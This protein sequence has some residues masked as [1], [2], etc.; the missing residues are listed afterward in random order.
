MILLEAAASRFALAVAP[1]GVTCEPVASLRKSIAAVAALNDVLSPLSLPD[2]LRAFWTWWDA[3]DF[4]QPALDGFFSPED[5]L[6]RREKL[7]GI[8]YPTSLIPFAAYG[9]GL[10]WMELQSDEHPGSRVYHGS[11]NDPELHLW[12]IGVS[13]LLDLLTE[14]LE[15]AGVI[16]WETDHHRLD[17]GVFTD[18]LGDHHIDLGAPAGD[19]AVPLADPHTWPAHWRIHSAR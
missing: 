13:G 1:H 6:A 11:F 7:L 17:A 2:E 3:G 4:R 16:S 9:R 12:T 8:G 10:V 19:W 15:R 14:C 5:A 18:V